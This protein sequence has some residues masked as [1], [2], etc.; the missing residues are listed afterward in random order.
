MGKELLARKRNPASASTRLSSENDRGIKNICG[1]RV[2]QVITPSRMAGAETLLVRLVQRQLERG[3]TVHAIASRKPVAVAA[4]RNAGLDI[5][6][7]AIGGKLNPLAIRALAKAARSNNSQILHTHL[8]SASWWAGWLETCG[9]VPSLGHVHGFT[10]A[11][12]HRRQRQLVA[13]SH[14]V[15]QHLVDQGI[16]AE[17]I[18][19]LHNPVDPMDITPKRDAFSVRQELATEKEA[20]VIG[21][22]AHFSEKKGWREFLEAASTALRKQPKTVFWCVGDGPLRAELEQQ[23]DERNLR[24]SI[25]FL[26]F[27]TDVADVMNAIDIMALPSHREPFG[28]VYVEAGLL[29]KPV[30]ACNAGGAPE[31]VQ[32]EQTGLLVPPKE[33]SQLAG[34]ILRLVENR[35]EAARFGRLGREQALE[36]FSWNRFLLGLDKLYEKTAG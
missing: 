13:C 18:E 28:L 24:A 25:R 31:V 36:C 29:Q 14:A 12:W 1:V 20:I 21:C 7:H 34:A 9:G 33:P 5:V 6:E 3:Q 4:L 11:K 26:G 30:I 15:K 22:F 17:K 8:S 10:S 32:H 2:L 16:P 23:V 27:R 19:A 35:E